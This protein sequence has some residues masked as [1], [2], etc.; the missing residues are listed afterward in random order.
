MLT[1]GTHSLFHKCQELSK[2]MSFL[3]KSARLAQTIL[4][5]WQNAYRQLNVVFLQGRK[6]LQRGV[7]E[8]SRLLRNVCMSHYL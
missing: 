4:L 6:N 1:T 8:A 2:V 7:L 3:E 5:V